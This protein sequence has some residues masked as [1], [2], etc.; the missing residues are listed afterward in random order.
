MSREIDESIEGK[1]ERALFDCISHDESPI[2]FEKSPRTEVKGGVGL[3]WLDQHFF[4]DGDI[5][6][7]FNALK[8]LEIDG[9]WGGSLDTDYPKLV[10]FYLSNLVK[11]NPYTNVVFI[12]RKREKLLFSLLSRYYPQRYQ[13]LTEPKQGEEEMD[14]I[15][16]GPIKFTPNNQGY[17]SAKTEVNTSLEEKWCLDELIDRNIVEYNLEKCMYVPR[18]QYS[19]FIGRS[20]ITGITPDGTTMDVDTLEERSNKLN[21]NVFLFQVF[22]RVVK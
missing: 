14:W 17:T 12:N 13:N 11:H 15:T 21:R 18:G 20:E 4:I 10:P 3:D 5:V 7:H 8:D 6:P 9:T 2:W 22:K 1:L 16:V 19:V